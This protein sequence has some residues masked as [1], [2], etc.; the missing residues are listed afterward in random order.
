MT[1]KSLGL[2]DALHRYLLDHSD[3]VDGL[4]TEL[5]EETAATLPDLLGMQ[6]APEQ[7]T[8]L[9]VLTRLVNARLAVEVGTFTGYS[10]IC[11]ARGLHRDGRLIC[12]DRSEAWTATA[13]RY[14]ERAGL[15]DRVELRVGDA[16]ERLAELPTDA[17]VD[18]AFIDADKTGYPEYYE[19]LRSRLAPGGVMV[20]D[21]VLAGGTV[22]EP[23]SEGARAIAAFNDRVAGDARVNVAMLPI[24]DG[25]SLITHAA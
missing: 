7:G 13:Q 15:T 1:L 2:S 6:I 3:P 21:N 10:S 9:T 18:L 22:L 20:V 8:F 17:H 12:F 16:R 5:A 23:E 24:A 4:L 14:W 25:I 19:L 11:I